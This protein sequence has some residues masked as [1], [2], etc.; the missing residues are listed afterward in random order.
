MFYKYG[1]FS[2]LLQHVDLCC[3]QN[4]GF[5]DVRLSFGGHWASGSL[6]TWWG[7]LGL[8]LTLN[9]PVKS[10]WEVTTVYYLKY[11]SSTIHD[12][13]CNSK[14]IMSDSKENT[15]YNINTEANC[16]ISDSERHKFGI[17]NAYVQ[18]VHDFIHESLRFSIW[19][20][21]LMLKS[22]T[23]WGL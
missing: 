9:L 21:S 22:A 3:W 19:S 7:P 14:K 11:W 10:K 16:L 2:N 23:N 20:G 5:S 8:Q 4:L 17:F 1:I 15:R 12:H 13:T 18:G 6:T